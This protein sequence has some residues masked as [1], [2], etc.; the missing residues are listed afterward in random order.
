[1]TYVFG[2]FEFDSDSHELRR[3]GR[4]VALEP[5]PARALG[6]LLSR[7]GEIVPREDVSAHVWGDGTHVD[8][9]R[10]IAYC[11]A[12]IRSALGDSADNPRFVQTLPKRGFRFIGPVQRVPAETATTPIDTAQPETEPPSPSASSAAPPVAARRRVAIAGLLIVMLAT[13]GWATRNV[14]LTRRP[15][16]RPIVAV[17]LFDNETGQDR[18]DR[19]VH[20]MS[21]TVVDRLTSLGPERLGVVGNLP[22]LRTPRNRRDLGAIA[23]QTR[24]QF[25]ILAQLQ[26]K[27]SALSLLLQLIRLDDGTHVWVR[28]IARESGSDLA[29]VDD[30]AAHLLESAVLTHV[31]NPQN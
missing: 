20:A 9:T 6:L 2:V 11:V 10:G 15:A 27:G 16:G 7:A 23:D 30:D 19:P 8:F 1:V 12:Q 26:S 22:P 29:G 25:I 13:A 14:L 17:A 5:Q 4:P 18:Y 24:A 3:A 21:D 28:R 31:V